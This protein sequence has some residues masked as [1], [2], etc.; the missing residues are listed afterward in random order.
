MKSRYQIE[1]KKIVASRIPLL[2][3]SEKQ[4][5]GQ[6]EGLHLSQRRG[7]ISS[8]LIKVSA[9]GKESEIKVS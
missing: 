8:K 1:T 6:F 4:A 3:S 5:V 9:D 7:I 2:A